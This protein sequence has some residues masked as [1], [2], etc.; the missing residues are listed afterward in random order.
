MERALI[1]L[2]E[3]QIVRKRSVEIGAIRQLLFPIAFPNF[4]PYVIWEQLASPSILGST[5]KD[6]NNG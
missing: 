6:L 1:T 5:K 3:I 4:F 2:L